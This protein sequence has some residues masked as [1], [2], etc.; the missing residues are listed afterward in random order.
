MLAKQTLLA[1]VIQKKR[2]GGSPLSIVQAVL[3]TFLGTPGTEISKLL[4]SDLCSYH[5]RLSLDTFTKFEAGGGGGGAGAPRLVF[6][7]QSSFSI[8]C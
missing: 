7:S 4:K 8:Y 3:C 2:L 1:M 5:I 6:L